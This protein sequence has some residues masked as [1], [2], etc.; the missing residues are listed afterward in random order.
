MIVAYAREW[1]DA[2]VAATGP[3][4]V[5]RRKKRKSR[6]AAAADDIDA[7][8]KEHSA[9]SSSESDESSQTHPRPH[10]QG[11]VWKILSDVWHS[12][13]VLAKKVS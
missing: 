11:V 3:T 4:G 6:A 8:G 2:W 5:I 9:E 1:R 10:E 7:V 13:V 12:L